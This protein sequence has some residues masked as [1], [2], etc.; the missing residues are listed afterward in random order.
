[1]VAHLLGHLGGVVAEPVSKLEQLAAARRQ[2]FQEVVQVPEQ[3]GAL[4]RRGH[5]L[6]EQLED[7]RVHRVVEGVAALAPVHHAAVAQSHEEPRFRVLD[8]LPLL[9]GGDQGLLNEVLR[10]VRRDS[11]ASKNLLQPG[12]QTPQELVYGLPTYWLIGHCHLVFCFPW[13]ARDPRFPACIITREETIAS[14]K[15]SLIAISGAAAREDDKL[16]PA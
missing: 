1:V 11:V 13:E 16:P 12:A 6:G 9:N 10:V 15:D 2:L 8:R 14:R 3:L 7:R 5:G 4:L